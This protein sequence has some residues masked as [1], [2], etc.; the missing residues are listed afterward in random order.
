VRGEPGIGKSALL[1]YAEEH[2]SGLRVL[3]ARGVEAEADL[4][5]S[6]LVELLRPLLGLLEVLPEA[7]AEALRG[8][9]AFGPQLD[10]KLLIGLA[11]MSLLSAAAEEQPLL[12][13]VDD[14][15]WLDVA[16]A[17]AFVF[18]VR[19]LEDDPVAFLFGARVGEPRRF[20]LPGAEEL[21]LGGLSLDEGQELL[22]RS[23]R[24]LAPTVAERL[25]EVVRGNPLA[26]LELPS[27]L[28]EEQLSGAQPLTEPLPVTEA[29]QA[30][31]ARR[32][33]RLPEQ[34]R[35]RAAAGADAEGA[36]RGRGGA[37]RPLAAG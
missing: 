20:S 15:H 8:T 12:G 22:A 18:A 32:I 2:S 1:G 3:R 36:A 4:P 31:F 11:T 35:N 14:A 19:R 29:V 33:E 23:D 21:E 5:F 6:A 24:E 27:A 16:S 30:A 26:L 34:T 10:G 13:V 7:Q 9:F 28:G 25:H 17:E 37:V